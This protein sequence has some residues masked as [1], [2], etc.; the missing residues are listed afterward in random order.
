MERI[1]PDNAIAV[2]GKELPILKAEDEVLGSIVLFYQYVEDPVWI[3]TEHKAALKTVVKLGNKF[4]ITGRGRVA[5][6]E[7]NCTLT[8]RPHDIQFFCYVL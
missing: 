3:K 2:C 7:L 6:E 8:S 4:Y 5:Q 1:I